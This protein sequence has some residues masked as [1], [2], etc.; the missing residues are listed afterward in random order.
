M[1]TIKEILHLQPEF[2]FGGMPM[3]DWFSITQSGGMCSISSGLRHADGETKSPFH[4][5]HY[6]MGEN[7]EEKCIEHFNNWWDNLDKTRKESV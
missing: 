7:A 1:L 5:E 2:I 6:E 3:I 4:Y